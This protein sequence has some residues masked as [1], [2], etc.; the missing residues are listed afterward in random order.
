MGE[1]RK[2]FLVAIGYKKS[3]RK[4]SPFT[5]FQA[6][7]VHPSQLKRHPIGPPKIVWGLPESSLVQPE[8]HKRDPTAP[9]T[10]PVYNTSIYLQ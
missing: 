6:A 5:I 2:A 1:Y 4:G 10:S 3:L 8:C 7:P 9:S